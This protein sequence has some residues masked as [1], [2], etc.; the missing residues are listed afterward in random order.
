MILDHAPA[1]RRRGT[2]RTPLGQNLL[3]CLAVLAGLALIVFGPMGLNMSLPA[4]RP[5][6][7]TEPMALG[8][9]PVTVIPPRGA[10][11]DT[12]R[13]HH[14]HL[15]VLGLAH[16]GP[17]DRASAKR[18]QGR[19]RLFEVFYREPERPVS[20]RAGHGPHPARLES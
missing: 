19:R 12:T 7:S 1:T 9:L 2:F 16:R 6:S 13:T 10:R 14:P 5:V 4:E 8:E 18:D 20:R 11:L 3:G 15:P 17:T